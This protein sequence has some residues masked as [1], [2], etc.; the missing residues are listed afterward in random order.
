MTATGVVV[1]PALGEEGDGGVGGGADGVLIAGKGAVYV[2]GAGG[3]AANGGVTD[4][5][6]GV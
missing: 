6:S 2:G 3:A 1:A 5:G 4:G